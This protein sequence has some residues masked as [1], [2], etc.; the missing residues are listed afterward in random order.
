MNSLPLPCPACGASITSDLGRMKGSSGVV[1]LSDP[2][3]LYQCSTCGIMFRRPYPSPSDLAEAYSALSTDYWD[4]TEGRTDFALAVSAVL[5]SAPSGCIL[6]VGCFRGDFLAMFSD[7]YQKYGIEP[8]KSAREI[9]RQRGINLIGSSMEE[10]EIKSPMFHFITLLDVIEHLPYPLK[11][12]QKIADLLLPGGVLIVSTGNTDA[13]PWRLM[14]QDYWYYFTEHVSFLS[15]RWFRWAARQL[16]LTVVTV[17]K[18]SH[19]EGSVFA[20][21]R[22][23]AQCLVFLAL[24]HANK[25]PP[26]QKVISSVYPFNRVSQWSS[27]PK[28]NLWKDHMLVVLKSMP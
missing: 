21:W 22:Q 12:L 9:A 19:K 1:H 6:D 4:Y 27:P 11:S 3:N 23:L 5:N 16:G 8:A 13:L 26:L 17:K 18:F 2:G 7:N 20:R 25:Y 10:I 24:K 28:T 14:G 15:P